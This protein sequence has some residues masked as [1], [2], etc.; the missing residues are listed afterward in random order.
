MALVVDPDDA[1]VLPFDA[2]FAGVEGAAGDLLVDLSERALAILGIDHPRK[3]VFKLQLKLKPRVAEKGEHVVADE[4]KALVRLRRIAKDAAGRIRQQGLHGP[5]V[6]FGL[7]FSRLPDAL[8]FPAAFRSVA[9]RNILFR[10][11][12]LC[13]FHVPHSPLW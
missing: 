7:A 1:A 9:V 2:V 10:M 11:A 13:F 3:A 6:I 4:G 5:G 8:E 12:V